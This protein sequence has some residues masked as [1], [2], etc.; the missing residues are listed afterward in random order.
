MSDPATALTMAIGNATKVANTPFFTTLIDKALGFKISQWAAEGEVR[1]KIIHDEYEK[2]KENGIVGV[3]YISTLRSVTNL[4]DTAVKSTKYIESNKVNEIKMD[5]DFFWNAIDHSKA[6]SAE[7]VQELIAKIIAEEYNVPGSCSM[8][9]LQVIK[10]LGKKELKLFEKI[11]SLLLD[12]SQTPKLLFTGESNVREL[13]S[14]I[15]V[16]FGIFQNLQSLGLFLPNDMSQKIE[17][18]EKKNFRL[19]YFDKQLIFTPE[20]NSEGTIQIPGFY[21]L[22]TAGTQILQ[23]LNPTYIEDYYIWLKLNYKI[24]NYKLL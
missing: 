16:D 2:A 11:G 4:I 18:P 6:V 10:M 17:N 5:N 13:M 20:S 24:P 12:K 8:S 22:S 3:Q 7:E 9:T 15:G 1:K 19:Q 23:H 21:G 14:S